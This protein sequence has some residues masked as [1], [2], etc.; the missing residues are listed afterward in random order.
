MINLEELKKL[1]LEAMP[2]PWKNSTFIN[3]A[4]HATIIELIATIEK[5]KE[6]L[7]ESRFFVKEMAPTNDFF[8]R[9]DEALK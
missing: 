5:Q 9:I 2:G 1:A 4:N 3:V 8:H 7:K 6:L